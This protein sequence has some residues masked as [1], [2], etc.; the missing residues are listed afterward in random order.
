MRK[1]RNGEADLGRDPGSMISQRLWTLFFSETVIIIREAEA[2]S[3]LA[4]ARLG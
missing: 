4:E 2:D 1:Q 3:M